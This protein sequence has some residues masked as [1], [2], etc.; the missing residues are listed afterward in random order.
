MSRS[1]SRQFL[2]PTDSEGK[3]SLLRRRRSDDKIEF[4][5]KISKRGGDPHQ[6]HVD[7]NDDDDALERCND[8]ND[9]QFVRS[10]AWRFPP[11]Q[12]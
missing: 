8:D 10:I 3:N 6:H 5:E 1:F 11:L 7:H 12:K 9:D 2:Q 4:H